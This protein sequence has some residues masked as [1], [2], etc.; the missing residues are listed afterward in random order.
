MRRRTARNYILLTIHRP[1]AVA[2]AEDP[3]GGNGQNGGFNPRPRAGGD[4][5]GAG[6]RAAIIFVSIHAPRGAT[7]PL[8]NFQFFGLMFL[9]PRP[10][11]GG[12]Q[13]R[14]TS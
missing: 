9:N 3:H 12:R 5:D 6:D 10:P 1:G 7:V 13:C 11:R 2:N 8:I 4:S 14:L